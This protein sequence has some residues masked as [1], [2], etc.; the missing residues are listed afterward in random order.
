MVKY[1][2]IT[3]IKYVLYSNFSA[4]DGLLL[5]YWHKYMYLTAQIA[6]QIQEVHSLLIQCLCSWGSVKKIN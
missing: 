2:T 4:R 5:W 6:T 1:C 3:S